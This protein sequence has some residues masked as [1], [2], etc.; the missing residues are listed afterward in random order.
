VSV[1]ALTFRRLDRVVQRLR[2]ARASSRL[3]ALSKNSDVTDPREGA[4]EFDVSN[5]S[6]GAEP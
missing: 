4:G 3:Q 5:R 1:E 2:K 6:G